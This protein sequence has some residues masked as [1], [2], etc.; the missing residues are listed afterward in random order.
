M[1]KLCKLAVTAALGIMTLWAGTALAAPPVDI[2]LFE[3]LRTSGGAANFAGFDT[4]T[5]LGSITVTYGAPGSYKSGLF[6]DH[7]IDESIN[8]FFNEFGAVSGTPDAALSWEIDE[9][10]YD[11]GDI[12][13]NFNAGTL[14]NTNAISANAVNDVSMALM[15][16]FDLDPGYS[17]SVLFKISTV[18]P[19]GGFYLSQT[20]PDSQATI[21]FTSD[22]G[23]RPNDNGGAVPEPSTILLLGAGLAGLGIFGRKRIRR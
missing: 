18:A 22:L 4:G 21:Y 5:G 7:E 8:T 12:F 11:F 20:D 13:A 23:I 10:G 14:D 16:G 17:A 3:Y 15:W 9:P 2:A 6:V 1:K 19:T